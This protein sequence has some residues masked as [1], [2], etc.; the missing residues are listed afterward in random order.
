M[1]DPVSE[2][3]SDK[4]TTD[5]SR[6]RHEERISIDAKED[7]VPQALELI[8]MDPMLDDE[9]L[10]GI[11][12]REGIGD[13][14]SDRDEEEHEVIDPRRREEQ[15]RFCNRTCFAPSRHSVHAA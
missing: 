11:V 4:Q 10:G 2:W 12:D 3:I 6:R 1:G 5:R 15:A 14:E 13:H 9:E 7:R 8:E